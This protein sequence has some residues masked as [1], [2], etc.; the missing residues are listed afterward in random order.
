MVFLLFLSLCTFVWIVPCVCRVRVILIF[1]CLCLDYDD[2]QW[3]I[4][5]VIS[6]TFRFL[7]IVGC[8]NLW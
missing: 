5:L 8:Y 1:K 7:W 3:W 6:H 2:M 4:L